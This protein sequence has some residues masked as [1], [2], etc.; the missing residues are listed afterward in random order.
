[1]VFNDIFLIYLIISA[2]SIY[3]NKIATWFFEREKMG[4]NR[5]D[6]VKRSV[7]IKFNE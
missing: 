6:A 7:N 1:M 4:A 2:V 3:S 5:S